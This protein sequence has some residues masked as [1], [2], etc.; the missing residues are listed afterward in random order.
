MG[1]RIF[2]SQ[3]PH[4]IGRFYLLW[5]IG[6]IGI[7]AL[8]WDKRARTRA[9]FVLGFSV[10][11]FLA[12]CPGLYF[13]PHYFVLILP[14][15]ALLIGIGINSLGR[16]ILK[17]QPKFQYVSI[18]L[19]LVFLSM[20]VY[21]Y[22]SFF[23]GLTPAQAC[24]MMYGPNPFPESIRIAEYIKA[25]SKKED[26]I[27]I[28]GSEPQIYFYSCRHSATGYI[29]VYGLME[30]QKYALRMQLDMAREIEKVEPKYLILVN[31]PTSWLANAKSE[32]Y[33]FEWVEEYLKKKFSLVG[34]VDILSS[35]KTEYRWDSEAS[36]YAPRSPCFLCLY[37][38]NTAGD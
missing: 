15:V 23:F 5:A 3:A 10:F 29:Y 32:T 17:F 36:N 28:L 21:S 38:N 24:R 22:G 34:V 35:D 8:F 26:K 30:N 25:H 1:L 31:I 20:G 6:G 7:S 14:A 27:A 11:S 33:I 9:T 4:I 12:V 18:I 16:L 37:K 19:F 13:R 2:L